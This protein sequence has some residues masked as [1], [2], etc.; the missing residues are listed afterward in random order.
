MVNGERVRQVREL[1]NLTQAQLAKRIDVAQA[2]IAKIES[3]ELRPSDTLVQALSLT[4][5]FPVDFFHKNNGPNI[6]LGS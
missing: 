5:G 4:T 6:P 2:A 1:L 3:G